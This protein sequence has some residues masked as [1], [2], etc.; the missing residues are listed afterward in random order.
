[1]DDLMDISDPNR[2][3]QRWVRHYSDSLFSWA[4]Y[5]TSHKES[6]EDLVQDTFI[7]A[8][9]SISTIEGNSDPHTWLLAILN[10]KIE[11]HFRKIYHHP[12]I[13]ENP[14]VQDSSNDWVNGFFDKND[15]WRKEQCPSAWPEEQENLL[16]DPDFVEILRECLRKLSPHRN[17]AIQLKYLEAKKEDLIYP[18]WQIL[19]ANLWQILH[20]AKLELRR[21]LEIN[22]FKK[23]T[24]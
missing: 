15:T 5:K 2:A 1:M 6:A 21:C 3:I 4:F 12:A 14:L 9:H 11:G 23:A 13:D 20:K 18:E 24:K 7:Q 16:A 17:A 19:P 22:W 10:H 8:Y